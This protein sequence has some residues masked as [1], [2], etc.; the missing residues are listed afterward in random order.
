MKRCREYTAADFGA[1]SLVFFSNCM[2]R[3]VV[4]RMTAWV[5]ALSTH[6]HVR[7][8]PENPMAHAFLLSRSSTTR[9]RSGDRQVGRYRAGPPTFIDVYRLMAHPQDLAFHA[10]PLHTSMSLSPTL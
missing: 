10:F 7:A 1:D 4:I 9:T 2:W 5:D 6:D 3:I 8:V